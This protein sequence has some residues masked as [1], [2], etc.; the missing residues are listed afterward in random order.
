[1][2]R[3]SARRPMTLAV[4]FV[5]VVAPVSVLAQ[6]LAG[7]NRPAAV[8]DGYVITPFGYFH[9]SCVRSVASG[10]TVL[11][12]GRIQHADGGVEAQAASCSYPHYT[13]RGEVVGP[14]TVSPG[15]KSPTISHSWIESG[16][17]VNTTSAFGR[18]TAKWT[19]PPAPPSA[20]GQTVYVFPGMEDYA[21]DESI[22][23]P[24]LGWNADFTDAWG[25]AS[26]NCCTQGVT[27]ESSPVAVS[28]GDRIFGKIEVTC[29]M[30]ERGTVSCPTS[31]ITTEDR[32]TRQ[33]TTLGHTP[34]EGQTYT[35][36]QGGA[37]EVYEIVQ[38]SDYPPNHSIVFSD[39]ALYD[40]NFHR[41]A[42]PGWV[43]FDYYTGLAP[44]CSYGVELGTTTVTLDY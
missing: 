16:D 39:L 36:A 38:C 19:V 29:M 13:A 5:L 33:S 21:T 9:P 17:A 24:V 32:T 26:W 30:G 37:L 2:K 27:W 3:H 6:R 40:Y 41:Y 22:I 11:A 14:S 8:P 42:N 31:N 34:N 25:I 44:Q 1:M 7:P 23:Q 15:A 18:L 12:D 4:S 10:D 20:D 28:S 35:W 43:F